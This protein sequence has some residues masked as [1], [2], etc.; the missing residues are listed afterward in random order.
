[1]DRAPPAPTGTPPAAYPAPPAA[2]ALW[3]SGG[4]SIPKPGRPRPPGPRPT[5]TEAEGDAPEEDEELAGVEEVVRVAAEVEEGFVRMCRML[6]A[7]AGLRK[8]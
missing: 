1:M 4:A 7:V 2:A 5:R 3:R 6:R 8:R